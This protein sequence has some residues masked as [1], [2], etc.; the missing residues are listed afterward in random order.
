MYIS[1]LFDA[2]NQSL[3]MYID[4]CMQAYLYVNPNL[5]MSDSYPD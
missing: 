4:V 3:Q 1:F 2:K 5:V